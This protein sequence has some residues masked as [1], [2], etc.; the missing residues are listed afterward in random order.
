MTTPQTPINRFRLAYD[1]LSNFYP[2][3]VSIDGL[4][5][6]SSEAAFQA[7]KC[8]N[9]EDRQQ[10]TR[11]AADEAKRLGRRA[12]LRSD[13]EQ[14]KLDVMRRVVRAKFEQHPNLAQYLLDTG[15]ADLIEGNTWNDVYWGVDLRT[16]EGENHLGKILMAQRQ[17]F[18]KNGLPEPDAS[19]QNYMTYEAD[20]GICLQFRDITE[21][22]CD[23]IVNAANETLLGG[24]GVDAAIHRA[25][26]PELLEECRTLGGCSVAGAKMTRGYRLPAKYVIHTVG[27]HYGVKGDAG[28]LA[29]TYRNVLNLAVEHG[30]H[31]IALPAIS[32]GKFRYPKEE[33]T[34]I[35]VQAIR[36]WKND[37]S[38]YEMQVTLACVDLGIYNCFRQALEAVGMEY[39]GEEP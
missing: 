33:A 39:E 9:I 2:A 23:C 21:I 34:N 30:L 12:A 31:S 7:Y 25:A 13:W 3:T 28:L 26:G 35:A 14:V 17:E 27:P 22:K 1:F 5:Y 19:L 38:V 15:D 29:M 16:G 11:I 10:F 37:H 8:K 18:R 24:G 36:E 4:E 32:A 6:L 20:D